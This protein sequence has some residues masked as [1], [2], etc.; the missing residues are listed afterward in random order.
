[1]TRRQYGQIKYN[2]KAC[3]RILPN[4]ASIISGCFGVHGN[5]VCLHHNL[6]Q[7]MQY[8]VTVARSTKEWVFSHS[9]SQPIYG[10]GQGS[11]NSPHIWTMISSVLLSLFNKGACGARYQGQG[12]NTVKISSTVFVDN[13]KTPIILADTLQ[14]NLVMTWFKHTID[15]KRY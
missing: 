14:M 2:A 5:I 4:L 13:V 11:G 9:Q 1:M 6:L 7:N 15:G 3:Y 8:H 12:K 10:I